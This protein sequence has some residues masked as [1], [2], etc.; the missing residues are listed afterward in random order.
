MT[1][2]NLRSIRNFCSWLNG[3]WGE[4][5]DMP[6]ACT[7]FLRQ[8]FRATVFLC[9]F[10]FSIHRC[11]F[12]SILPIF[13]YFLLYIMCIS[14][15]SQT[16][17]W[18]QKFRDVQ[19]IPNFLRYPAWLWYCSFWKTLLATNCLID[20]FSY[21]NNIVTK[22]YEERLLNEVRLKYVSKYTLY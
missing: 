2:A 7:A 14:S 12:G 16:A 17:F 15:K 19:L 8:F 5:L 3:P 13:A 21:S 4:G 1:D 18:A 20:E 10:F 22:F 9:L 6:G 11:L